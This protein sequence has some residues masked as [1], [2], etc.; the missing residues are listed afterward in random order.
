MT[1]VIIGREY[2]IV[3]TPLIEQ[4]Q[5][6]IEILVFDW[7]WYAHEPNSNIQKFNNA[8]L[9]A[10]QRGVKVRALVNNNIMPTILQLQKLSVKRVGTKS[11]MHVKM[12]IIDQKILVSGSHNFSKNAFEFNHEVSIL[13]ENYETIERLTKY[14]N[15]LCHL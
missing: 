7:R 8:I 11:M 4:A 15:M 1:K 14:F 3:V 6:T 2:P 5:H 12:I 13:T 9:E 10:S